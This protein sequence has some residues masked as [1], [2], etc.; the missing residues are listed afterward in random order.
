MTPPAAPNLGSQIAVL[1]ERI[2]TQGLTLNRLEIT[3]SNIEK[4]LR[5]SEEARSTFN[6]T[7]ERTHAILEAKAENAHKRI[8]EHVQADLPKWAKV[9][10]LEKEM[11]QLH[12]AILAIEHTNKLLGWFTGVLGATVIVWFINSILGLIK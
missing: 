5:D 4:R 10:E 8:D 1:T 9:D 12:D 6:S 2:E 11:K 3:L 7:Y